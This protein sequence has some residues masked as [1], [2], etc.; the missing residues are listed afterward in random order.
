MD[1]SYLD[2]YENNLQLSLHKYLLEL[3]VVDKILPE[4]PDIEGYWQSIA[5]AYLPD[6]VREFADYPTVSLGWMIYI[7]MATAQFWDTAWDKYESGEAI[8][9]DLINRRGYDCMDEAIRKEVLQLKDKAYTD[10]EHLTG[11]LALKALNFLRHENLEAGTP[12][13]FHAYVR[14]LHQLYTFGAAIQL[15]TL[16]YHMQKV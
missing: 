16:G 12:L 1:N 8:Y 6:G 3:D 11:N 2:T 7:G 14:T 5:T 13:A 10:A 9:Q 15:R 4:A